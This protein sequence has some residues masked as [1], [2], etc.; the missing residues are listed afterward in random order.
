MACFFGGILCQSFF[1]ELKP[2]GSDDPQGKRN[3]KD[4]GTEKRFPADETIFILLQR[5][6]KVQETASKLKKN[7]CFLFTGPYLFLYVQR[8]GI[9]IGNGMTDVNIRICLNILIADD[10]LAV[11]CDIHD[12][13]NSSWPFFISSPGPDKRSSLPCDHGINHSVQ[14]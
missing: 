12:P 6:R 13:G 4:P 8:K 9:V 10:L 11:I 5:R 2:A 3:L 7:R 1:S 14:S